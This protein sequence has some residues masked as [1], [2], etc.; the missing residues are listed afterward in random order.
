MKIYES[1]G[2]CR[3]QNE[4]HYTQG[5]PY[6]EEHYGFELTDSLMNLLASMVIIISLIYR[7]K[8]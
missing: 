6:S 4:V 2:Q 7:I 5:P 1:C 3:A 8:I